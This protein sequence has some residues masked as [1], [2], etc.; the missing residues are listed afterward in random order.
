[1]TFPVSL[2]CMCR[3][4]SECTC[5]VGGKLCLCGNSIYSSNNCNDWPGPWGN[6]LLFCPRF[7][8]SYKISSRS[9]RTS[10]SFF[11]IGLLVLGYCVGPDRT[12]QFR[13]STLLRAAAGPVLPAL[14]QA[15]SNR[16]HKPSHNL[17]HVHNTPNLM[18]KPREGELS[19]PS[20]YIWLFEV[21]CTLQL[22]HAQ[23][24][25]VFGPRADRGPS[26]H[27]PHE[28]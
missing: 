15:T 1:M 9:N 5:G 23:T 20:R 24:W 28:R 4:Y 26:L 13:P 16:K 10:F 18:W 21:A 7:R 8:H 11:S 27:L 14:S 2:M 19:R 3:R 6:F 25:K 22:T 12:R 17:T